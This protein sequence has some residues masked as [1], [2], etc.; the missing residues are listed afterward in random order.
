MPFRH[1]ISTLL[2]TTA[3]GALLAGLALPSSALAQSAT[4]L[5]PVA[6]DTTPGLR[7]PLSNS[8]TTSEGL[9]SHRLTTSDTSRLLDDLLGTNS[10]AGGGISSLPTVHGLGDDRLNLAGRQ[11]PTA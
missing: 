10:A 4:P 8:S 5:P 9:A 1:F 11:L 3:A 6:V 7:S 2:T